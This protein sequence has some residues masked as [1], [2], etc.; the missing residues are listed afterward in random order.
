M[1]QRA[2]NLKTVLLT[3]VDEVE[4]LR[5]IQAVLVRFSTAHDNPE[6]ARIAKDGA[7]KDESAH[8]DTL[9]R[10]IEELAL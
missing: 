6:I 10:S 8:Y 7:L 5:A 9:R 4:N 3:L 1:P 2:A